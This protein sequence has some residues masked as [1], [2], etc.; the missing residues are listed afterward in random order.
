MRISG[1]DSSGVVYSRSL[2]RND[3]YMRTTG[4]KDEDMGV[5]S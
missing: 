3:E 5:P 2:E 1:N 4:T